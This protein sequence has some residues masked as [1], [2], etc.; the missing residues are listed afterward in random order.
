MIAASMCQQKSYTFLRLD[1]STPSGSRQ[2]MV[3]RFN[4]Q[5]PGNP[6]H[7]V[8]LLSAKAGGCGINLVG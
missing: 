7:F 1:G 3:N 8:F 5:S 6:Q 2:S 4:S